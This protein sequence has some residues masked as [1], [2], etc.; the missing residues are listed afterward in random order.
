MKPGSMSSILQDY[1]RVATGVLGPAVSGLTRQIFSEEQLENRP[2]LKSVAEYDS[3]F[4]GE[5]AEGFRLAADRVVE[6][7]KS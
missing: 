6:L 5:G 4:Y 1:G 2:I 7:Q 3:P